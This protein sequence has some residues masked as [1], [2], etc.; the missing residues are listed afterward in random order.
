M[1]TSGWF[2]KLLAGRL[3]VTGPSTV[4]ASSL[5]NHPDVTIIADAGAL[6]LL[7]N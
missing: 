1:V 6:S 2:C 3:S 4:P 7:K 5:Q